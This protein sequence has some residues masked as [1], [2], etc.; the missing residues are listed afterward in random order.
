MLHWSSMP[1]V[2]WHYPNPQVYSRMA[3]C[4]NYHKTVTGET[5]LTLDLGYCSLFI[6]FVFTGFF[7]KY[8]RS[9]PCSTFYG[10]RHIARLVITQLDGRACVAWLYPDAHSCHHV[11]DRSAHCRYLNQYFIYS[12]ISFLPLIYSK[13]STLYNTLA[14]LVHTVEAS[15]DLS[16]RRAQA[17]IFCSSWQSK[18]IL[19][20]FISKSV[21]F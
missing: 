19:H 4:D 5:G 17:I 16:H 2:F 10:S 13:N 8:L 11:I 20:S 7:F 18:M 3:L 6:Y 14:Q 1:H 9:C 12:N 15:L 21:V